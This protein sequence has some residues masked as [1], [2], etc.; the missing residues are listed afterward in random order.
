MTKEHKSDF[1]ET[2]KLELFLECF[3]LRIGLFSKQL[4][5]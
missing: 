4:G 3:I 1:I 2:W 5:Q